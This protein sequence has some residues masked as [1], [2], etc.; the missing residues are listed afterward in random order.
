MK[1]LNYIFLGMFALSSTTAGAQDWLHELDQLSNDGFIGALT[2]GDI[3]LASTIAANIR[4]RLSGPEIKCGDPEPMAGTLIGNLLDQSQ[5]TP[6]K[7]IGEAELPLA[8]LLNRLNGRNHRQ[9]VVILYSL[10]LLGPKA[11]SAQ[12]FL[13]GLFNQHQPWAAH[14]LDAIACES[15]RPTNLQEIASTLAIDFGMNFRSCKPDYLP[16]IFALGLDPKKNWPHDAI[17]ETISGGSSNC[18]HIDEVTDFPPT[19]AASVVA[20]LRNATV[21]DS[22]KLEVLE[23]VHETFPTLTASLSTALSSLL[24]SDNEDIRFAAERLTITL[25]TDASAKIFIRWL[26]E[27]YS[28]LLWDDYVPRLKAQRTTVTPALLRHMNAVWWD[29][30]E[31]AVKGI[32]TLGAEE[33]IPQLAAAV[34]DGDWQ[35][36]SAI[37]DAIK[38][39]AKSNPIAAEALQ[40][41]AS[42]YWSPYVRK[43]AKLALHPDRLPSKMD[44]EERIEIGFN[45]VDHDLTTCL[46]DKTPLWM[47]PDG[48]KKAIRWNEPKRKALPRG[49]FADVSSWCGTVGDFVTH[50]LNDGWL[51]GCFG[52]EAS[53]S[54]AFLPKDRTTPIKVIAPLTTTGIL[55]FKGKLYVTGLNWFAKGDELAGQLYQLHRNGDEWQLTPDILLPTVSQAAA[56]V[57]DYMVFDDEYST[58]AVDES[59]RIR[60]LSCA[61][62]SQIEPEEGL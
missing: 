55:E 9:E 44:E 53:G 46:R 20:L 60:P 30:R 35:L 47:F 26:D 59:R 39:F 43:K 37:I 1:V 3:Q 23:I 57:D 13:S 10:S 17:K 15:Y 45:T 52:F 29:E 40:A 27:G 14:A 58:V 6:A 7:L 12:A 28:N 48:S 32:A 62:A 11:R 25:G 42:D 50:E 56:V 19:L 61:K 2:G 49:D 34:S 51:A 38:P 24:I 54:L 18:A 16:R 21:S 31:A 41:I 5:P 33:S 22:R 36:T 8:P 4:S